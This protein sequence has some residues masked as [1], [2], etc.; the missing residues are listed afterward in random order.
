VGAEPA[1]YTP[2][3]P[4][5]AL[6]CGQ[7]RR[8]CQTQIPEQGTLPESAA[9]PPRAPGTVAGGAD[10]RAAV[11]TCVAAVGSLRCH[12]ARTPG[13]PGCDGTVADL[14][15][16]VADS[17]VGGCAY[18]GDGGCIAPGNAGP[19]GLAQD[20]PIAAATDALL[21]DWC[22]WRV[23]LGGGVGFVG[24]GCPDAA[25]AT[26]VPD[27]AGCVADLRTHFTPCA[28]T[29][30]DVERC[31]LAIQTN[32]ACER[33]NSFGACTSVE[34]PVEA[35]VPCHYVAVPP[36]CAA[37]RQ[38]LEDVWDVGFVPPAGY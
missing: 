26:R 10:Y 28:V 13:A 17:Y 20:I 23:C 24:N 15:V 12:C 16:C 18:L 11:E 6:D 5:V 9:C 7:T 8:L 35:Y 38:C 25:P 34:N 4:L 27:V 19:S 3:Q 36:G 31:L 1:P 29:L 2:E 37:V 33:L 14:Q 30:G 32:D 22:G 21:A